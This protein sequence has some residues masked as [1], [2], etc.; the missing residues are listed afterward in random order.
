[1][2]TRPSAYQPCRQMCALGAV[3]IEL[4]SIG[5]KDLFI[6]RKR[7][8]QGRHKTWIKPHVVVYE[9][10]EITDGYRGAS[11]QSWRQTHVLG[12]RKPTR[13]KLARHFGG[14]VR[15]AIV[16]HDGLKRCKG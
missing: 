15:R 10:Q 5:C 4:H 3:P 16:H 2:V 14:V 6:F 1:M 13:L 9:Q 12:Q 11:I 7:L 8:Y